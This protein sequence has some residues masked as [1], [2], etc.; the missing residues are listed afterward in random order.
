[1]SLG[2]PVLEYALTTRRVAPI[3]SG[4]R[5]LPEIGGETRRDVL[6]VHNTAAQEIDDFSAAQQIDSAAQQIDCAAQQIDCAAQQID[7][8]AHC[9]TR[10]RRLL[11]L[12][13]GLF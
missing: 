13:L 5:L 3:F 2:H 9:S 12:V 11:P 6:T 7:C 1:M 4:R 8:A 10:N